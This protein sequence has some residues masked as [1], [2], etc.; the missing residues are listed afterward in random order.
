MKKLAI[1]TLIASAFATSAFATEVSIEAADLSDDSVTLSAED[2]VLPVKGF[3]LDMSTT[4]GD[5]D[6]LTVGVDYTAPVFHQF[7]PYASVDYT[8][9]DA[10]IDSD[11]T[12]VEVGSE[13]A[14]GAM[15]LDASYGTE[16]SGR[17]AEFLQTSVAYQ[18]D[19]KLSS[20]LEYVR[21]LE[22]DSNAT[23]V[24][25]TYDFTPAVYAEVA[26]TFADESKDN[27]AGAK[28]GYKF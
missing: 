19:A 13:Y 5:E 16:V 28:F 8:L 1:A 18:I 24:K 21:D 17:D 11:H 10:A 25:A 27:F 4:Q 23:K 14:I 15:T 3:D 6:T 7:T 12:D 20:E 9:S 2:I 22:N 26:Y